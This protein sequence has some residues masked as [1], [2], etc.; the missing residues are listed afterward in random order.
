MSLTGGVSCLLRRELPIHW[1]NEHYVLF[2]TRNQ[3]TKNASTN[4]AQNCVAYTNILSGFLFQKSRIFNKNRR[5]LHHFF[6]SIL[7]ALR[8]QRS[9]VAPFL[10]KL[11]A[12]EDTILENGVEMLDVFNRNRTVTQQ[13]QQVANNIYWNDNEIR[14]Q[15]C[16]NTCK[17]FTAQIE[18]GVS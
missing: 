9:Y 3:Y 12:S 5:H 14:S 6:I 7:F 10:W 13:Q 2:P 1:S 15:I 4:A 8:P 18:S 17:Y 11:N 16:S